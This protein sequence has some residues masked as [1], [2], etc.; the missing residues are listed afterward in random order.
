MR[1]THSTFEIDEGL[2]RIANAQLGLVTVEQSA[3]VGIDKFALARRRA[4]GALVPVFPGVMRLA[5]ASTPA[6]QRIL[7]AAFAV[8]GSTIAGTSAARVH[9]MPIPAYVF[10]TEDRIVLSIGPEKRV[11]IRGIATIRQATPQIQQWMN[12]RLATPAS[13]LLVLPRFV[14][15]AVVE[16]CIDHCLA[17]RQVTVGKLRSLIESQPPS[18]VRGRRLLLELVNQ[19]AGGIGHRSGTEQR[20]GRWL[21]SAGLRGWTR[22]YRVPIGGDTVEVDF[23]WTPQKVALE[24]SPFFTHGSRVTQERDAQR[25][26]MLVEHGWRTI[27]AT[28]ADLESRAAFA[29][30]VMSLRNVLALRS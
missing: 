8:P 6:T 22:N 15:A 30:T 29:R 24:V 23:S 28:D 20:V 2:R 27:E 25:R 1:G 13:A 12:T 19:R 14:D 16:R 3:R 7:A 9:Q 18:A 17:H 4:S 21:R 5:A 26:R 10:E 11:N